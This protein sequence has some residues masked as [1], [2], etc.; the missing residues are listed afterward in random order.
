MDQPLVNL[1]AAS[2]AFV[3]THFAMSPPLRAG[4]VRALGEKGF[5]GV[6][7]LEHGARS[8]WPLESRIAWDSRRP[9]GECSTQLAWRRST[10]CITRMR[11][12][13]STICCSGHGGGLRA[14]NF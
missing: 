7:S 14:F 4:M 9:R 3:G 13:G 8:R 5:A 6:Y 10:T 11:P 2:I 12:G 1:I